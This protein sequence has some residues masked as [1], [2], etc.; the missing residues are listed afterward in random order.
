MRLRSRTMSARG[1]SA[2]VLF[3]LMLPTLLVP[4]AGLGID[5]TMCY[6][7]QAKLGS[8]ADGAALAAGRLLGATA[9]PAQIASSVLAANFRTDGT[10]GFWGANTLQQNTAFTLGTSKSISVDAS[11]RVPLLFARIFGQ[12]YATVSA[13][14]TA[15]RTDSRVVLVLDR[16]GSMSGVIDQVLAAAQTFTKSF[17]ANADE[18]GLVALSGSSLVAYPTTRPWTPAISATSGGP[19]TNF[20]DGTANDMVNQ[21]A[22]LKAGGYTATAESLWLAY[23]ELQKAH[24]RDAAASPTGGDARVNAIIFFTDGAPTSLSLNLNDPNNNSIL[25]TSPCTY[26][27]PSAPVP[28][29]Q[30]ML[31]WIGYAIQTGGGGGGGGGNFTNPGFNRLASIDPDPANTLL[32]YLQNPNKTQQ[33]PY[34]PTP[35]A[36]CN[37]NSTITSSDIASGTVLSQIPPFDMYGNATQYGQTPSDNAALVYSHFVDGQGNTVT[38]NPLA[39]IPP[40]PYNTPAAAA[41]GPNWA[42]AQW[43]AS[44]NAGYRIRNDV[45]LPNR[46]GDTQNMKIAIYCIGYLGDGGLDDG[47]LKRIANDKLSTSYDGTQP[48]GMYIPAKNTTEVAQAFSTIAIEI[49]RLAK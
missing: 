6:I 20:N 32:V 30:Q 36:G 9:D 31:G 4:L 33:F 22:S 3:T 24:L 5:A 37:A 29:N 28:L 38:P 35:E 48:T 17:T 15:L 10:A 21:I 45:N 12:S 47:L 42:V 46:T 2:L 26:K 8:A 11:V 13:S 34:N 14:A 16:S 1:G 23:I 49:L 40:P 41:S 27:A 25:S 7:V 39:G 18:M 43:N 19:D 44:D